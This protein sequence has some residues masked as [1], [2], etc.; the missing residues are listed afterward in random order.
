MGRID[1]GLPEEELCGE[2]KGPIYYASVLDFEP[3]IVGDNDINYHEDC[4]EFSKHG[5]EI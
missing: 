1:R 3:V 4:W 2:C 5:G